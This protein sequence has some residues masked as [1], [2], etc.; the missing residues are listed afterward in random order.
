MMVVQIGDGD[1]AAHLLHTLRV[2]SPSFFSHNILTPV[3]LHDGHVPR[4]PLVVRASLPRFSLGMIRLLSLLSFWSVFWNIS[5]ISNKLLKN[6]HY[7]AGI[8]YGGLA[9]LSTGYF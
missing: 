1:Y 4:Q 5:G 6:I 9:L 7:C 3:R 8:L 2:T